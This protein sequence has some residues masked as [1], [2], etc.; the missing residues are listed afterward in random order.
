ME[1]CKYANMHI[2]IYMQNISIK[3]ENL[4]ARPRSKQVS[5][6]NIAKRFRNCKLV[7]V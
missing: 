4:A 1:Q 7:D 2:Y 5:F 6:K 3:L